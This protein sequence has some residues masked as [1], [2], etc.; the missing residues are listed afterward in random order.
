MPSR[1]FISGCHD[2][3][4]NEGTTQGDPMAMAWFSVNSATIIEKLKETDPETKQTLLADDA[5]GGSNL[6]NLS[7][8]YKNIAE[9]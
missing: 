8:W 5:A 3:L 9:Y 4:S 1:L 2:I 7:S 6:Q